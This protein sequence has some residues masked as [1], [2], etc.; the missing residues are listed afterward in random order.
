M[1]MA[2]LS[3]AI[4]VPPSKIFAS[5]TYSLRLCWFGRLSSIERNASTRRQNNYCIGL[6]IE[7]A[8]Q[9]LCNLYA[10]ESPGTEASYSTGWDD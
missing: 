2:L 3:I 9:P 4:S 5:G 1:G 6:E 7:T 8:T 10:F